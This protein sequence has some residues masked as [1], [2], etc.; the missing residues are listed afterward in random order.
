MA[1][2]KQSLIVCVLI[3]AA[4][5][6]DAP[7]TPPPTPPPPVVEEPPDAMLPSD[8]GPFG[9]TQLRLTEGN[10][11]DLTLLAEVSTCAECHE[12]VVEQWKDSPHAHSSF[13]N[14]WYRAGVE[15][16]RE[17]VGFAESR[18]C[19]GCHDP[20]LTAAGAM[21]DPIAPTDPRAHAGVTCMVC[22]SAEAVSSDG[23]GSYTLTSAPVP[24]PQ[25]GD[26]AS[27]EAHRRRLRPQ[28]IREGTLCGSCHRGFLGE[29]MGNPHFLSGMDDLGAWGTSAYAGNRAERIDDV[30]EQN[31]VDCH[32]AEGRATRSGPFART[33]LIHGHRFAGGQTALAE[34]T[35]QAQVAA[36][37]AMLRKAVSIDLPVARTA[38]EPI[39]PEALTPGTS[40]ELDLVIRNEGAGHRFPGGVRDTQDSWVEV[41]VFS[42]TGQ[43]LFQAGTKYDTEPDPGA[44]RL[45]TGLLTDEGTTELTHAIRLFRAVGYDHTIG[46][47][48]AA[49]VRYAL[50]LPE[51]SSY[52]LRVVARLRHRR[53]TLALATM[54]CTAEATERS[55]AFRETAERLGRPRFDPCTP[56]PI[57]ELAQ[58]EL[59]LGPG[60]DDRNEAEESWHRYFAHALGLSHDVQ[61]RLDDARPSL[62]RARELL[63]GQPRAEAMVHQLK[64][65]IEGR[66]GRLDDALASAN[67]AEAIVGPHPAIDR[68]RGRAYAQVW[69]WEE[70]AEAYR[71]VV[72]AAPTDTVAWMDLARALGSAG[73]DEDALRAASRGLALAPRNEGLLRSQ[74]LALRQLGRPEAE[75]AHQAFIAHRKPDQQ[76]ALRLRCAHEEPGCD[77]ARRPVPTIPLGP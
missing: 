66:Q 22:H 48:D 31:C 32:M 73:R 40:V 75:D 46:A 15:R 41:E 56:Q 76:S 24:I 20:V 6:D 71:A 61:E 58:A 9:P 11:V 43:R 2:T 69:Q 35:S 38:G 21:D 33:A 49:V 62:Q 45:L 59:W 10:A 29:A 42:A 7:V 37:D 36:V 52:P 70:A 50:D 77:R 3:V 65:R 28:P 30:E 60:A 47:R 44:Y 12:D 55:A 67:D 5:G 34:A 74:A 39:A 13:N 53:H 19:G 4:C 63:S 64:A 68:A 57:R 25:R 18:F 16:F 27:V 51:R 1:T 26:A 72:E 54:T 23:N 8:A 14:P 17:E